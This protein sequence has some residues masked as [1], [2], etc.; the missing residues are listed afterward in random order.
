MLTKNMRFLEVG[1]K[2][3]RIV[4][5]LNIIKL[6]NKLIFCWNHYFW[7]FFFLL[8]FHVIKLK[9]KTKLTKKLVK[10]STSMNTIV[11]CNR[12]LFL[13]I[14]PFSYFNKYSDVLH[15]KR[16][17]PI[18]ALSEIIILRCISA[19]SNQPIVG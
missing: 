17:K 1:T 3:I 12:Y 6:Q 14:K 11:E 18:N 8:Q 2:E 7:V 16:S 4:Y 10:M 9:F 19:I 15:F 13:Y 5:F